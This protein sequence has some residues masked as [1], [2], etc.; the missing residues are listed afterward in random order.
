MN[1]TPQTSQAQLD[2]GGLPSETL[3][4]RIIRGRG[5]WGGAEEAGLPISAPW[6]IIRM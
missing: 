4:L 5:N 3:K 2:R 1:V 6:L